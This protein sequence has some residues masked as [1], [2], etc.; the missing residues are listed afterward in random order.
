MCTLTIK[1]RERELRHEDEVRDKLS[2]HNLPNV[3]MIKLL[4]MEFLF[5]VFI[6]T[7]EKLELIVMRMRLWK[8]CISNG[9]T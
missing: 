1:F 4:N 3:T 9:L 8:T 2:M 6:K 7:C 5:K